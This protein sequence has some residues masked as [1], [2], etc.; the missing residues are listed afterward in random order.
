MDQS[1][2][3]D[4]DQKQEHEQQWN[5][6]NITIDQIINLINKIERILSDLKSERESQN[7][8]FISGKRFT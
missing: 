1:R 6:I 5:R 4:L 3:R 2:R 7:G 8:R